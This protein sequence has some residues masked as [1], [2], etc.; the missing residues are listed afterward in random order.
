MNKRELLVTTHNGTKF[1]IKY[2]RIFECY[3]LR[4]KLDC[5]KIKTVT[6]D[7]RKGIWLYLDHHH[8]YCELLKTLTLNL[9]GI[10]ST[11]AI[12]EIVCKK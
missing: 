4:Y 10:N 6:G 1:E 5:H 7:M 11:Q 3:V 12:K 9:I 8:D 2:D